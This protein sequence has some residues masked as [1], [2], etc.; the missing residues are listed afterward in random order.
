VNSPQ[1]T[2]QRQTHRWLVLAIAA[3]AL[4][5]VCADMTVLFVALPSL[6]RD[7]AASPTEH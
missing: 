2:P 1:A 5:L 3:S 6:T 4:F 7:L